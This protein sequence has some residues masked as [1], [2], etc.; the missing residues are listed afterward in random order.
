MYLPY[1]YNLPVIPCVFLVVFLS[2]SITIL[3]Q[4]IT[5][6]NQYHLVKKKCMIFN[7][8]VFMK[9]LNIIY[10][11]ATSDLIIHHAFLNLQCNW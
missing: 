11:D 10:L 5:L 2:I 8:V 3:T 9:V 1:F 4:N 7:K 6:K